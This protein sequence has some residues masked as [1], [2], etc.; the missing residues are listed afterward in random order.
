MSASIGAIRLTEKAARAAAAVKADDIVAI[1][2][3]RQI[4]FADVFLLASG[5]NERQVLAIAERI[6]EELGRGGDRAVRKEGAR[7]GRWVLLDFNEIIVH[8]FHQEERAYYS[9]ERLWKDG[10]VVPLPADL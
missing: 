6:E 8:V 5:S 9:L 2:V 3:S 7:A 10:A 1:D 4:P